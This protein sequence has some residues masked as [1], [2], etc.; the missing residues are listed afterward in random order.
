MHHTPIPAI[1]DA[2]PS[3]RSLARGRS[4]HDTSSSPEARVYA[5]GAEG[6]S[7]N[8][9]FAKTAAAGTL[10]HEA[11]M[12]TAF[13]EL[14]LGPEVVEYLPG[15]GT[16]AD[17]LSRARSSATTA[18][19]PA[20]SPNRSGCAIPAVRLRTLHELFRTQPGRLDASTSPT[21]ARGIYNVERG[22]RAGRFD[23]QVCPRTTATDAYRIAA[24]AAGELRT[25]AL[26]HGDYCLP[27]IILDDWRF[28][29]FIDLRP[30]GPLRP[31]HRCVLGRVDPLVQSAHQRLL[32]PFPR[33]LWPRR[34]RRGQTGRNRCDGMLHVA[35]NPRLA[36]AAY[37]PAR[38]SQNAPTARHSFSNCSRLPSLRSS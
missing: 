5:L 24:E 33:C 16:H 2:P 22:W 14:G 3:I 12:S 18:P 15:G 4:I 32:Q 10:A 29:G 1:P 9:L 20:T 36:H 23:A 34:H 6:A 11:R 27:N 38:G 31:A 25:D 17:W 21:C 26:L 37:S 19:P 7:S 8:A 35:R 30:R 28:S 13:H